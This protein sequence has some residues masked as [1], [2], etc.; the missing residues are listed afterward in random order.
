VFWCSGIVR[1]EV[2][3]PANV[4]TLTIIDDPRVVIDVYTWTAEDVLPLVEAWLQLW[5]TWTP[6]LKR[7]TWLLK[8][9]DH[10]WGTTNLAELRRMFA[11]AEV[12]LEIGKQAG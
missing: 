12:A 4:E 7:V 8:G 5:R 11:V 3:L 9:T 2:W 1:Q 10:Q 6:L